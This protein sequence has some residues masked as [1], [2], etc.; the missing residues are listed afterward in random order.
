MKAQIRATTAA[1]Y[2]VHELLLPTGTTVR[3]Y[4]SPTGAVFAVSWQGPF[5]PDLR[6]LLGQYFDAFVAAPR[7]AASTRSHMTLRTGTLVVHSDGHMRAFTGL[8][9]APQLVPAGVD[10]EGLQ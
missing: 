3:E 5:K 4:L 8:A 1:S 6:Q 2:T 10:P 9:Y 7:E